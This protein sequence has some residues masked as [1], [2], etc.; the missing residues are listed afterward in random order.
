[1]EQQDLYPC[2]TSMKIGPFRGIVVAVSLGIAAW[3]IIFGV[4]VAVRA[5]FFG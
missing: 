4:Y 1:M 5:L 2:L 3:T